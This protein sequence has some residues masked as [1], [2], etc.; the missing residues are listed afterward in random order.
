MLVGAVYSIF[1][2]GKMKSDRSALFIITLFIAASLVLASCTPTPTTAPTRM[3][4]RL[5]TPIPLPRLSLVPGEFYFR[6][7]DQPGMIFSRNFLGPILSRKGA[8]LITALEL[9]HQ[10]GT[11]LIRVHLTGWWGTPSMK[12]DGTV[13]ETW[14]QNWDWF[15][16][17][18]EVYGIDVL[19]VFGVCADWNDAGWKFNPL[20]QA[21]GGYLTDPTEL[22]QPG[23][24]T[25]E[26]WMAWVQILVQRWQGRK[27]ILGWEIFSEINIASGA[28]FTPDYV[29]AVTETAA[30][31]FIERAAGIIRAADTLDRP[32]T[33]SLMGFDEWPTFLNSTAIDFI[34]IH[35]YPYPPQLDTFIIQKTHAYIATYHKPVLI[36]ESGLSGAAPD[37]AVG[38]I[39]I[40]EKAPIGISHAIWAG[41]LSGA[42]NGRGLFWEDSYALAVTGLDFSFLE[43]YALVESAAADFV[44]GVD[45]SGFSPLTDHPSAGVTGAAIGNEDMLL[46]WYRDAASEPPDWNVQTIPAGKTVTITIPG[47][48]AN[49]Q[50]DFY[51]TSTGTTILSSTSVTRQGSTVTVT[52]PEF[53]DDIAF[54]MTT[55]VATAAVTP[56]AAANT[57][58]IAGS[59]SGTITNQAGTFSTRLELSIQ[60]NCKAGNIC[61][62]FN[63]PQLPCSG[64]LFLQEIDGKTYIFIEQN[65]TGAESCSSGGYEYLQLQP[66]G[67]LDY[68]FAVTSGS[69]FTSSGLL[70]RP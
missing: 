31:K 46:G 33:A 2:G 13:N 58:S 12:N 5:P 65:V 4:T 39:T 16:N 18:A 69:A 30:V 63:V 43:K 61:G 19:P 8:D 21:N 35:P 56:G 3:P 51:D 38:N 68:R 57:N 52:L 22:F 59:W 23:S 41:V 42:M 62:T 11:R 27:N 66:D 55:S 36:G 48:A 7:D 9:A 20:N 6:L 64:D 15:F 44:E 29:S 24:I 45:F 53:Q 54:K 37:T 40:A 60:T 1:P 28:P 67:R 49:W 25:Q 10:A 34:N 70:N 26:K 50:V 17:Q 47:K 14:A 32:T